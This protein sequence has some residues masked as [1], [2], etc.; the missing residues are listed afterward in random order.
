MTTA[1]VGV[2]ATTSAGWLGAPPC[3]DLA[4]GVA[5][6]FLLRAVAAQVDPLASSLER[7]LNLALAALMALVLVAAAAYAS[8]G[9]GRNRSLIAPERV[10]GWARPGAG[11]TLVL[12]GLAVLMGLL[13]VAGLFDDSLTLVDHVSSAASAIYLGLG[14]RVQWAAASGQMETR[15]PVVAPTARLRVGVRIAAVAI[16][17]AVVSIAAAGPFVVR[18][19]RERAACRGNEIV[20][21]ETQRAL[22][23]L[24]GEALQRRIEE[25]AAELVRCPPQH[26]PGGS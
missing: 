22:G 3:R 21:L 4:L 20:H 2:P 11:L 7:R 18:R 13:V 23:S 16:G 26:Q 15:V 1:E 9:R 10:P 17:L 12:A 5:G 6:V 14:L 25:L 19:D 8:T 24:R